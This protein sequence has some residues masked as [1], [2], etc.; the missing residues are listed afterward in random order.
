MRSTT[1]SIKETLMLKKAIAA[2]FVGTFIAGVA[3]SIVRH[4]METI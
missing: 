3:R 4:K 1:H 2:L